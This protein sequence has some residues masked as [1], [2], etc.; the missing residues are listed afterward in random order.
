MVWQ[1]FSIAALLLGGIG[2]GMNIWALSFALKWLSWKKRED[3]ANSGNDAD[4]KR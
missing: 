2:I 4:G 1:A 3:S